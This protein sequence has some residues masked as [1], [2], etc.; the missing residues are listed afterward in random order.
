MTNFGQRYQAPPG[1]D[2]YVVIVNY[3]AFATPGR[4]TPSGRRGKSTG[5]FKLRSNLRKFLGQD[6]AA[7]ILDESHKVK[8]PSGKAANMLVSMGPWFEYRSILTGTPLTKANRTHDVYRQ[9]KFLNPSRF[10]D[11]ETVADFKTR[12]GVWKKRDGWDQF[13]RPRNLPELQGRMRQD[14]FIIRRDQCFD[15]PPREDIVEYVTLGP[16]AKVYQQMAEEM[17]AE[18]EDGSTAEAGL[19]ITQALRLGQITSGFVTDDRGQLKRLGFE[20]FNKLVEILDERLEQDLKIVV[21]ARWRA[22]LDLVEDYCRENRIPY[23]SVRGKVKREESDRALQEFEKA[24]GAA[25]MCVQPAAAALGI[26]LS[27][28]AYMVWYSHTPSWVDFTQCCDRIALSRSST[29]FVHIVARHSVD[30]IVL[31]TLA[32]DGDIHRA[33]MTHPEELIKGRKLDLD[34]QAHLQG[35]GSFQFT[36]GRS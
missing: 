9:W 23:Y 11:L 5:R 8:N 29:T 30:E 14:S 36:K 33:I 31:S 13:L 2:L 34:D 21:A 12:Y 4:R 6:D 24:E 35:I 25:I 19:K 18:L 27:S 32:G 15:L 1:Y 22:D 20:K 26:D 10:S 28:A 16:S 7:M 17:I 3:D